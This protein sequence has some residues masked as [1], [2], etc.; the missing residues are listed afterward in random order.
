MAT[1]TDPDE[2]SQAVTNVGG[3][4]G[5]VDGGGGGYFISWFHMKLMEKVARVFRR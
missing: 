2:P 4:G 5:L 1:V 3:G